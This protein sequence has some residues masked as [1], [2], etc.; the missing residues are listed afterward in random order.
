LARLRNPLDLIRTKADKYLFF[1]LGVKRICSREGNQLSAKTLADL[2][3][4]FVGMEL[5]RYLRLFTLD[6]R[7]RYWRDHNGPEVDYV[8]DL[9]NKYIPIEV[10]WTSRPN[11]ED[12]IHLKTFLQEYDCYDTAYIICRCQHKLQLDD[13]ITALPWQELPY[14][15][16]LLTDL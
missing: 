5:L 9:Y 7:L 14:L 1:D 13:R 3:E 16:G 4:Q 6:G 8:I 15:A 10:K 12:A 2:F 11:M